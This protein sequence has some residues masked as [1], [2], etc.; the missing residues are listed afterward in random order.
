[1]PPLRLALAQVNPSVGDVEGNAALI[2]ARCREAAEAGTHLVVFGEMALTGYPVEDLALRES[3]A[4]GS[5]R[6]L[7]ALA[8]QLGRDGCTAMAVVVGYLD[9][10]AEGPRNAIAVLYQGRVVAR[11]FKHH[12]PN[13]GVFDER[14]YFTSGNSLS[15]L[16][17]HGVDVGIVI[18]EDIWQE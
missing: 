1:M 6:T 18:C 5:V 15:V 13:Y 8:S 11:Q 12:L 17:L 4:V 10:D 9:R 3:F 16:R 7:E 2:A 14:R